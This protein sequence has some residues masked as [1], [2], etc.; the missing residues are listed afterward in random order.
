MP[1]A[2]SSE[3]SERWDGA[4]LRIFGL[5]GVGWRT[6]DRAG[7]PEKIVEIGILRYQVP[8]NFACGALIWRLRRGTT[9]QD[10][11]IPDP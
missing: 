6:P 10:H 1:T 11:L 5:L 4:D 7:R 2:R 3:S 9:T 8:K